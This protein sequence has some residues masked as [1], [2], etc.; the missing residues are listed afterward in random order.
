M[1]ITYKDAQGV[2]GMRVAGRLAAEVLDYLTPPCGGRRVDQPA[3]PAGARLHHPGPARHSRA[4]ELPR[5]RQRPLPQVDL[6]LGQSPGLPWHPWRQG[7]QKGRHRQHRY[8][9]H[10]GW[11]AWRH[12]PHVHRRRH[13]DRGAAAVQ[14]HLRGDVAWHRD[15]ASGRA[16]GRHRLGDPEV[17]RIPGLQRGA[18]IL[19]SRYRQG[20]PR[21]TAGAALRQARARASNWFPA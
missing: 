19:R 5:W 18:R 20:V 1:T 13:L 11:L 7:A 6:H 16:I 3:R 2:A 12:Q 15:G 14:P 4:A 9:R 21:G 10:Q 8:H 17:R